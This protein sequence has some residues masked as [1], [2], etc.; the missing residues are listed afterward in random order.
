MKVYPVILSLP[1]FYTCLSSEEF[2]SAEKVSDT[3]RCFFLESWSRVPPLDLHLSLTL[4][5]A[6]ERRQAAANLTCSSA[7]ANRPTSNEARLQRP[8]AFF[9]PNYNS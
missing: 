6:G 1:L 3:W 9:S 2:C 4:E 5:A 7:A 8:P